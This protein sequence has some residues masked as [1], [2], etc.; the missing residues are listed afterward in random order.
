MIEMNAPKY[1]SNHET[2]AEARTLASILAEASVGDVVDYETL[3]RAIGRDV[4]G[5]ARAG[6]SSARSLVQREKRFVFS[7]VNNVGLK[8]LSDTEIVGLS[9]GAR[10]HIRRTSRRTA[11]KLTCVDYDAMPKDQQ[12][13]H[14]TA[15]SML[16]V[17]GEL[18]TD[19]SVKRLTGA[20]EQTGSELPVVKASIAALGIALKP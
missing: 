13:K 14:N 7:C 12:V 16:G 11:K 4:R 2:S 15:L 20:I 1:F 18:S 5:A 8:R 9:D 10:D 3:N 6:L 17:I 19:K